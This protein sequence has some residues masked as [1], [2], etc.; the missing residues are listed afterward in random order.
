MPVRIYDIA[1]KYN[2]KPKEVIEIAKSIAE[3]NLANKNLTAS[4]SLDKVTAEYLEER[5]PQPAGEVGKSEQGGAVVVGEQPPAVTGED[6]K[7]I[8]GT[9]GVAVVGSGQT[10]TEAPVATTGS[11]I[12]TTT[13]IVAEPET[14][15]AVETSEQG[16]EVET[17]DEE[18]E[19]EFETPSISVVEEPQ[20]EDE[21]ATSQ[22]ETFLQPKAEVK[23]Q[24][25]DSKSGAETAVVEAED[26]KPVA[27]SDVA[28]SITTVEQELEKSGAGV[29]PVNATSAVEGQAIAIDAGEKQAGSANEQAQAVVEEVKIETKQSDIAAQGGVETKPPEPVEPPKPGVGAKIG[30]I[31]ISKYLKTRGEK[32]KPQKPQQ[33]QQPKKPQP[34]QAKGQQQPVKPQP[35]RP[36]QRPG[37]QPQVAGKPQAGVAQPVK[38]DQQKPG[39]AQQGVQFPKHKEKGKQSPVVPKAPVLPPNAPQVMIKPP[40]LVRDLA[41]ALNKKPY[42]VIAELLKRRVLAKVNDLVD[43]KNAEEVAANF[44]IKLV[45]EKRGTRSQQPQ[46]VESKEKT[47]VEDET[48]LKPRPPVVTIMGHVDHGKTT[49]LDAIRKSNVVATEAGGITQHIGAYTISFPHPYDK[50][51]LQEITFIDTPGHAA[52]SAMRA[53]GANV[54]DIVILVVAADDGVMPQTIEALNHAKAAEV[55]IIVAINKCDHPNANPMRVKDQLSKQGLNPEEWGGDTV[56]VEVSALKKQGVDQLLEFILLKADEL[57]LKAN[58]DCPA[59]GN[60]IESGL[61]QGGPT[62]T[63]LVRRGTLKVGDFLVCGQFYG[64]VRA[65]INDRNERLKEAKPSYAVKVLGLNGVPEPGS[66][67]E[68][69]K[70]IDTAREIAE[71]RMEELKQ[72]GQIVAAKKITLESFLESIEASKNKVLKVVLKADTQGSVEAISAALKDIKSEKV[73]LEIIHSGVGAISESDVMLASAAKGV[74]IG[75]HT[76]LEHGVSDIAKKEGVQIKLYAIIYELIDEVKKAM[77]G[78]LEPIINEVIIGEASVKKVFELSKGGK[79]AG[80]M[81]TEGNINRGAKAKVYRGK[82]LI[83][84]GIIASIRHFQDEVNEVRAGMECGIR[85]DGFNDFNE[86][87]VIQCYNL[88]KKLQSL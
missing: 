14:A 6:V 12:D 78:L 38:K 68:A 73:S 10:Q 26:K 70:D 87:D 16:A 23:P 61:E 64:K 76:R 3:L 31:D 39:Q 58:P 50:K 46:K 20:T 54:T 17:A 19:T 72:Q 36:Q 83:Y 47:V 57:N 29:A 56:F 85:I 11:A 49:L 2:L 65:L 86:G 71:K 84:D 60:V 25:T 41:A 67:F 5:L 33:Q 74:I 43:E 48:K 35:G 55:P 42:Q 45:I 63:L 22:P 9:S 18:A 30:S 28:A 59:W 69:V 79:V 82:D 52:F 24:A 51:K 81:V 32:Q 27:A 66:E 4:S 37:Q 53:R 7:I 77:A 75:F 13:G 80:C 1:K 44:G 62:A 15:G 8:E 40:I 21:A 88:E 34:Q